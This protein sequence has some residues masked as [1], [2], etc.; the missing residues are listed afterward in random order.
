M[1]IKAVYPTKEHKKAA[2][3]IVKFFSGQPDVDAVI[4]YGSCARGKAA[5]G[6]CVD[7]MVMVPPDVLAHK[8]DILEQK[9]ETYYHSG[10]FKNL[11]KIGMYSHVDLHFIGGQ[12]VPQ[13]RD[14]T[15][16]PDEFE[17]EIGNT[18]VYSVVLHRKTDYI[19][20]LK[21]EFLPYYSEELRQSRLNMVLYYCENNLDHIPSFVDRKLYFQAFNRLYHA[22]QEFF[23]ALFISRRVYPIAYDKW[24][25]EQLEGV[26]HIPELYPEMVK[27]FQFDTFEGEE[28]AKKGQIIKKW[29]TTYIR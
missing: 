27:L 2:H 4:L 12:F 16:G 11:L 9:W 13:P 20:Q 14:F 1:K 6:S 21:K 3:A 19:D 17:L 5:R 18:L 29:I 7:I 25:K 23:Q 26:L 22:S 10:I 28:I 24:I 8:K 15:S